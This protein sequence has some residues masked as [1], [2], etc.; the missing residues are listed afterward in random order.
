[1]GNTVQ[2]GMF[3]ILDASDKTALANHESTPMSFSEADSNAGMP[4]R[5]EELLSA[6]PKEPIRLLCGI[7]LKRYLSQVRQA[8]AM[9]SKAGTNS[10]TPIDTNTRDHAPENKKS[11]Q[12]VAKIPS[13]FQ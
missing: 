4:T 7:F 12:E 13:Q 6:L 2:Q 8:I 1:M 3:P 9:P 11:F 5:R 10:S